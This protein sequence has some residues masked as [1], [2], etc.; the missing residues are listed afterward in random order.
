MGELEIAVKQLSDNK[1]PGLDGLPREF[2]NRVGNVI[3][4]ELLEILNCQL[5]RMLLVESN[6]HGA[7]RLVPKVEEV[8]RVYQLRPITLLC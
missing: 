5:D 2:Y 4:N 8:P 6:K 1:A 3:Y 7:T